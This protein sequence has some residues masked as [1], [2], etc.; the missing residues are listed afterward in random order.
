MKVRE[1]V[2]TLTGFDKKGNTI[3]L[4]GKTTSE[5]FEF[6]LG[7][8]DVLKILRAWYKFMIEESRQKRKERER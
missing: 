8:G 6:K 5:R 2:V 7:K 1:E 3:I 4:R